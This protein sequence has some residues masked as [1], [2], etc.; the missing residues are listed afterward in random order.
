MVSAKFIAST[1]IANLGDNMVPDHNGNLRGIGLAS[2]LYNNL[3]YPFIKVALYLV[4]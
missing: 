4:I 3:M 1:L 2:D